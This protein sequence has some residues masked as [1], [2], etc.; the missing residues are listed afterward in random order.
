MKLLISLLA[1]TFITFSCGVECDESTGRKIPDDLSKLPLSGEFNG[2]YGNMK[3]NFS[4]DST[5]ILTYQEN[6]NT[7]EL[8]YQID[9]ISQTYEVY[10]E[11]FV[12]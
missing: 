2:T 10:E 6:G 11:K 3:I 8:T 12:N 7:Y 4:N 5:A 1:F 9:T